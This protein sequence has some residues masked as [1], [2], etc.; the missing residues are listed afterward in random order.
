MVVNPPPR[1]NRYVATVTAPMATTRACRN[2]TAR[3][4]PMPT[5]AIVVKA[6]TA[7]TAGQ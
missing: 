4:T 7:P 6:S 5:A 2:A 3:S 1:R